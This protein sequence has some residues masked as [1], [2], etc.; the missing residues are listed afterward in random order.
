MFSKEESRQYRVA[1]WTAFGLIM[2]KHPSQ[3][4]VKVNWINY[5]SK[6]KDL[7]IRLHADNKKVGLSLDF[8]M[9][10]PDLRA[11]FWEQMEELRTV[12]ES[13]MG[14]CQWKE[15]EYLETG[16][17][18]ARVVLFK[19]KVSVFNKQT[20]PEAFLFLEQKLLAFDSFWSDFGRMFH[21]LAN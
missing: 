16:H 12:F 6:V 14:E 19:E 8:Q 3:T 5:Q 2:K 1:F 20:W 17:E 9:S 18:L 15:K 7:Y 4:G 21:N 10:D 13:E 11:L